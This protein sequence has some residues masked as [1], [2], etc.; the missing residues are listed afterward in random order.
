MEEDYLQD[1]LKKEKELRQAEEVNAS[2]SQKVI[3]EIIERVRQTGNWE[4]VAEWIQALAKRRRQPKQA[5]TGMIQLAIS[6]LDSLPKGHPL[7][8]VLRKVSEGKIYLEVEFARLTKTLAE[9]KEQE[10]NIEEASSLLQEVQVETYGSMDKNEKLNYLLEQLRLLLALKDYVRF[11]IISKKVNRKVLDEPGMEPAKVKFLEFMIQYY[12]YQKSYM[13]S[14]LS[15]QTLYE[16]QGQ[17]F[18]AASALQQMVLNLL[19]V[20][21]SA[22]QSDLLRRVED[23]EELESSLR[24]VIKILLGK[25]IG[26]VPSEIQVLLSPEKWNLLR[27]RI[28]QH[29]IRVV[30]SYY[31]K[32][33]LNR[34]AELLEY[35]VDETEAEIRDMVSYMGFSAKINR[36]EK[37]IYFAKPS[38]PQNQLNEWGSDIFGLLNRLEEIT[39]LIHR[40]HIVAS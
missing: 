27:R 24:H 6:Y 1:L 39:H 21:Y 13:D 12:D 28:N 11:F 22:E 26:K 14:A 17:G 37:Y 31:S 25:E 34:L 23:K 5:I 18:D 10:G 40:E 8:L 16:V 36:P 32:I 35:T 15:Y 20:P 4:S 9:L 38:E 33:T 19:L 2:E 30:Q 3:C 29:N 7:L